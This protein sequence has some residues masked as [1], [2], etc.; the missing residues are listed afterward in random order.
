LSE[1]SYWSGNGKI[2]RTLEGRG[3][4]TG[5]WTSDTEY[6][7]KF[8]IAGHSS[9]A[10]KISYEY[11]GSWSSRATDKWVKR[12]GG[13][14]NHGASGPVR[15][16]YTIDT[17]TM[18]IMAVSDNT[19]RGLVGVL[20]L[21][22]IDP[23]PLHQGGT[24]SQDWSGSTITWTVGESETID[25]ND[26]HVDVWPLSHS[27]NWYGSWH[28]G[29]NYSTGMIRITY[30]YDKNY[31]IALRRTATGDFNY[32]GN[33]EGWSETL[34]DNFQVTDSNVFYRPSVFSVFMKPYMVVLVAAMIVAVVV[35]FLTVRRR[36]AS[37]A[38][39]T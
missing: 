20:A 21:Q 22:L 30:L 33:D 24:V 7:S 18:K 27:G 6:D 31:G 5:T 34:F 16:D 12:N 1:G 15:F 8:T 35:T 4:Y 39:L 9:N 3:N 13:E 23:Q 29:N 2:H 17:G 38:R 37:C 28:A 14:S 11:Y 32:T 26:V 10:I 36:R 25:V 19:Y